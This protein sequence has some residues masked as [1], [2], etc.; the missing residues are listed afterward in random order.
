MDDATRANGVLLVNEILQLIIAAVLT[1]AEAVR[2]AKGR[3]A[4]SVD[5]H[6]SRARRETLLEQFHHSLCTLHVELRAFWWVYGRTAIVQIP[7]IL[8]LLD[9]P[10]RLTA[11]RDIELT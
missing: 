3:Y 4:V 7:E 11:Q 6:V 5:G 1:E 8:G 2:H 9:L 10:L